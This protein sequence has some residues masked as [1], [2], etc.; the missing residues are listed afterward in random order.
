M[1]LVTGPNPQDI[2][3]ALT[4]YFNGQGLCER[5]TFYGYATDPSR[6]IHLATETFGLSANRDL[7]KGIYSKV[8]SRRVRSFL[9]I[10]AA[11]NVVSRSAQ[12]KS[13]I[14]FEIN[15][16]KGKF[17]LSPEVSRIVANRKSTR[18][19]SFRR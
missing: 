14:T 5:I 16:P 7:G 8:F 2:T 4:Y 17:N 12:K 3:G 6:I 15:N 18:Q 11:T 9:A 13:Q 1:P 10:E 19:T